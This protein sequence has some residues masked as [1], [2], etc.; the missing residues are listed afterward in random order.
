[1]HFFWLVVFVVSVRHYD[2]HRFRIN[3]FNR[4]NRHH[5]NLVYRFRHYGFKVV[6]FDGLNFFFFSQIFLVCTRYK[7]QDVRKFGTHIPRVLFFSGGTKKGVKFT[8]FV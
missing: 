7:I 4:F 1:M 5:N 3:G 2:F 6:F 8:L